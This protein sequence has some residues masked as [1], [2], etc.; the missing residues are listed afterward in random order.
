MKGGV[1]TPEP[2]NVE[3]DELSTNQEA[4]TIPM[5]AGESKFAMVWL[6]DAFNQFTKDAP[7]ERPGKK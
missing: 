5:F 6:C 3:A 7:S 4:I 2:A 1:N